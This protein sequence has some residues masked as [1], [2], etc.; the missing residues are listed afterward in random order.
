M[1]CLELAVISGGGNPSKWYLFKIWSI[2][3]SLWKIRREMLVRGYLLDGFQHGPPAL[4][5][6]GI[7]PDTW[8]TR[9]AVPLPV[10]QLLMER[11]SK[12]KHRVI[13]VKVRNLQR[14]DTV[15]IRITDANHQ[16]Y[17]DHQLRCLHWRSRW[18]VCWVMYW[19]EGFFFHFPGNFA[20]E[21]C[22]L[23]WVYASIAFSAYL[24][25]KE[26]ILKKR[27][28]DRGKAVSVRPRKIT[29]PYFFL[30]R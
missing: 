1:L 23:T 2:A 14:H 28:S 15:I 20:T 8:Q 11:I 12:Q 3:S 6:F 26:K 30:R 18:L 4:P 13:Y 5:G 10:L 7:L 17:G 19:A 24:G 29:G 22:T 9:H 16:E 27:S 21:N 25:V